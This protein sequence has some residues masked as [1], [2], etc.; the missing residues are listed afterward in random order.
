[1]PNNEATVDSGRRHSRQLLL[2]FA[3]VGSVVG[4]YRDQPVAAR[5]GMTIG[6]DQFPEVRELRLGS[7]QL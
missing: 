1:M 7:A 6:I 4:T 3:I 5:D 2:Q